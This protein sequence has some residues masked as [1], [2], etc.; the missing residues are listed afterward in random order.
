MSI[1]RQLRAHWG[2]HGVQPASAATPAE[3]ASFEQAFG[4]V[5]PADFREYLTSLNGM[6]LGHEGAMDNELISF[7]RL[8]DIRRDHVESP[9]R[10]DL[11]AFA[12]WSIDA[13][14]Y[15][16][17]LSSNDQAATPVFIVGGEHLLRIADSFTDFVEGYLR[18]DEFVLYGVG[19][20][21]G[22]PAAQR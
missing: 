7:W 14:L 9:A 3:I 4:I 20:Q 13:H 10:S 2:S 11:F 18:N 12:D 6:D 15:A 16:L 1:T 19:R 8:S 5:L 22:S 21:R 17:Q